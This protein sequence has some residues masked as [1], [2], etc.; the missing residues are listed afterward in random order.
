M[1]ISLLVIR[2]KD[3]EVS[4]G[5]YQLL[6]LSFVKEKHGNGPAHYS[7]EHDGIVFELYPNNGESPQDNNRLGFKVSDLATTIKNVT[8]TS[9]Y[10]FEGNTIYVLTDPDG[11]KVEISE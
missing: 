4:K 9:S 8:V 7:C 1:K 5:F 2:C 6:G 10:E 11:R 3:I